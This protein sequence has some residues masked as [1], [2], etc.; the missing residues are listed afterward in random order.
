MHAPSHNAL[1]L[2][3]DHSA[4]RLLTLNR[5]Q[6]RNSLSDDMLRALGEALGA[7]GEDKRIRAVVITG[8]PPAFCAGHDLKEMTA[9]RV[10]ADRGKAAFEA[11]MTLCSSVMQMIPACPKPVIAAVNG[12]ATAAGCQLVAA[13]DLAIASTEARFCTPGVDIGLF[14][15][16]PAVPLARA[17]SRKHA[18]EM[19]L[20]GDMISAQQ[21]VAIG[22]VNRAVEPGRLLEEALGL[23]AKIASKSSEAIAIGKRAFYKQID[24]PLARAYD[25]A[26][27][28]MVENMLESDAAEGIGAFLEKRLPRWPSAQ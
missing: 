8:A 15:S 12:V 28:V 19:L 17:V 26:S 13:C 25:F 5:P 21:A 2:R 22:L 7:A 9:H 20:T 23:A 18:L 4:V 3:E 27:R 24:M 11:T 10:D 14:C 16:T 1:V 6:A